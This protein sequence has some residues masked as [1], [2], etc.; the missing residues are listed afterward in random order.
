[1][2]IWS[3]YS[4]NQ[5]RKRPKNM[6]SCQI[7]FLEKNKVENSYLFQRF[8]SHPRLN[9]LDERLDS[10]WKN[11]VHYYASASIL[12]EIDGEEFCLNIFDQSGMLGKN[13]PALPADIPVPQRPNINVIV[14]V[15]SVDEHNLFENVEEKWFPMVKRHFPGIPIILVGNDCYLRNDDFFL[16]A[17][18]MTAKQRG[19]IITKEMG[20][21]LAQKINATKYL[22]CSW[23]DETSIETIFEE[24]VWASLRRKKKVNYFNLF[25]F[26]II[27]IGILYFL[28][29]FIIVFFSYNDYI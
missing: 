22:E 26:Y 4:S 9:V 3:R 20:M 15:F 17:W 29:F 5:K 19:Q 13:R 2:W 25:L 27:L 24:A 7:G 18:K 16:K 21:Q 28:T 23:F 6:L 12:I 14:I 8:L 1:M 10:Y 11:P